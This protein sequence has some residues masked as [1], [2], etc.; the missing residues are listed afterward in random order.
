MSP[1]RQRHLQRDQLIGQDTNGRDGWTPTCAP[2]PGPDAHLTVA[3]VGASAPQPLVRL[4]STPDPAPRILSVTTTPTLPRKA[5]S[6]A[7]QQAPASP[8]RVQ[9][10]SNTQR[11]RFLSPTGTNTAARLLGEDTNG[12]NG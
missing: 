11:V 3:A 10:V 7:Y 8:F 12:G 9:T 4:A 2:D 6:C 1:H 5:G